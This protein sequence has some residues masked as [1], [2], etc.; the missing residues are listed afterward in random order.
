MKSLIPRNNSFIICLSMFLIIIGCNLTFAQ[1]IVQIPPG[2]PGTI[3]DVIKGDTLANGTHYPDAIYQLQRGGVYLY[4]STIQNRFKMTLEAVGTG[5]MPI[6]MGAAQPSGSRAPRTIEAFGDVTVKGILFYSYDSGLPPNYSSNGNIRVKADSITVIVDHCRFDANWQE[7]IR[8]DNPKGKAFIT[9]T[10]FSNINAPWQPHSGTILPIY[11]NLEDTL[12]VSNCTIY[13]TDF[14]QKDGPTCRVNYLK[15]EHT[16]FMNFNGI[17]QYIHPD[18]TTK[19]S[20]YERNRA[21]TLGFGQVKKFVFRNNLLVNVGF[22]GTE[23][24]SVFGNKYIPRYVVNIDSTLAADNK[25]IPPEGADIRNNNVW[26]DPTLTYPD[27]MMAIPPENFFDPTCKAFINKKGSSATLTNLPVTF[28]KAPGSVQQ[29]INNWFEFN[30]GQY[31]GMFYFP[32]SSQDPSGPGLESMNFSYANTPLLTASTKGQPLGDLNW[33]NISMI[34]TQD[35]FATIS[36]VE[37]DNDIIPSDYVLNQN[38]PNPFNPSTQINYSIPQSGFVSLKVFNQLGQEVAT[39]FS[40]EQAAGNYIANFNASKLSSGVYFY[41]LQVGDFVS[42]K[43][44]ML[45]K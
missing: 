3:N 30:K 26:F 28:T 6:I 25:L 7:V 17:N 31:T 29:Y 18:E 36:S 11:G 35:E 23:K 39:V 4:T 33:F 5:D 38:F 32:G 44:M 41:R 43:K 19:P 13:N 24:P 45:I 2:P 12:V 20:L 8:F 1:H 15:I 10:V 40:G 34:K 37:K 27:S 9:N 16:T 21:A 22:I 14:W 42:V